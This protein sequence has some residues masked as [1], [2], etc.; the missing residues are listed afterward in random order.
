M[1]GFR[2]CEGRQLYDAS[3]AGNGGWVCNQRLPLRADGVLGTVAV[4]PVGSAPVP[5]PAALV[6]LGTGVIGVM[7]VRR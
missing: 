4:T 1:Y 3:R 6:L 2:S 5:E 7:A